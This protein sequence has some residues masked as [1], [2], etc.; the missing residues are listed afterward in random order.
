MKWRPYGK[1]AIL[2]DFAEKPDE[3]AFH[4]CRAI[5]RQLEH[6]C[7]PQIIEFVPGYTTILLELQLSINE[8]LHKA[9]T[10]IIRELQTVGTRKTPAGELHK[11]PV[12]YTGPDL[13]RVAKHNRISA[14]Q[15]VKFHSA[16]I[17]KVYLLG[18][19]PGFP[20]L[21]D[22][23]HK[24][25]TPRLDSPRSKVPAGSVAIGGKHTGIYSVESP[26]GWNVIGQTDFILFDMAQASSEN[27]ENAFRLK[28]GD[29]VQFLPA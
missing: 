6:K 26:G 20:Y 9:A 18:F 11:I 28:P 19:S 23:H 21:G 12:S 25:Y 22:L 15:V 10:E 27:P 5:T 4:K 14:E 8:T 3:W 2:I 17:Y 1:N 24:L 16:T 7:P 29:L 13:E